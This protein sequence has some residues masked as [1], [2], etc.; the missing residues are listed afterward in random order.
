MYAVTGG[1]MENNMKK[2]SLFI[3]VILM[4]QTLSASVFAQT[5]DEIGINNA[6]YDSKIEVLT[7][8]GIYDAGTDAAASVTRA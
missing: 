7:R 2:I 3:S 1:R 4:I 5:P 8:L 6:A